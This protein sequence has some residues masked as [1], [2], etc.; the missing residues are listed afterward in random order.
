M[1]RKEGVELMIMEKEYNALIER[2]NNPH[3]TE[4]KN[5]LS[6]KPN[7]LDLVFHLERINTYIKYHSQ[8]DPTTAQL[9]ESDYI[10]SLRKVKEL[11]DK[12]G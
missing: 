9:M 4:R 2:L 8:S 3:N 12:N 10:V 7:G 11:M 5:A 1:R 6:L